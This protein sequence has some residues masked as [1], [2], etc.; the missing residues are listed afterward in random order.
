MKKF[1]KRLGLIIE[2]I[3]VVVAAVG[4]FYVVRS[5]SF[6]AQ[7]VSLAVKQLEA[8]NQHDRWN[9]YKVLNLRYADLL[10]EVPVEM[11][12]GIEYQDLSKNS[13]LW[14]RRYF[15]LTSE[16]YWLYLN[17]LMPKEM[18][19]R[20]IVEGIK[21]NME[22]YPPLKSGLLYWGQKKGYSHPDDFVEI[23]KKLPDYQ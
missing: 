22:E 14:I 5:V 11:T 6:A 17:N 2:I 1:F 4:L 18:W 16:E 3:G 13:K 21:I 7:N 23:V 10:A 19:E 12:T 8:A 15:D 20:R 9:N